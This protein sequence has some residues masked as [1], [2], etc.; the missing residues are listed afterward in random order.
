MA[1]V[2]LPL[3]ERPVN[4]R[5]KPFWPRRALRSSWVRPWCHVMFL[6]GKE[7]SLL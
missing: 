5:V 2:D 7:F 1:M 6:M 4:Q 3:A